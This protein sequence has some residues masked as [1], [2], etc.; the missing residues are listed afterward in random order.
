MRKEDAELF[1]LRNDPKFCDVTFEVKGRKIPVHKNIL[2]VSSVYFKKLFTGKF[3]EST[4]TTIPLE[5]PMQ[6]ESF[7]K[8]LEFIYTKTTNLDTVTTPEL[9][10]LMDF[11]QGGEME[12]FIDCC[13][14]AFWRRLQSDNFWDILSYA[15]KLQNKRLQNMCVLFLNLHPHW[16]QRHVQLKDKSRLE[17]FEVADVSRFLKDKELS[18]VVYKALCDK[19]NNETFVAYC[20]EAMEKNCNALKITCEAYFKI[21]KRAMNK[22][23]RLEF[24]R[25]LTGYTV[26][27]LKS[28]IDDEPLKKKQKGE[29]T[30]SR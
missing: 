16:V 6:A 24:I 28:L 30:L 11:A 27:D 1:D 13:I 8:L 17:L 20:Q 22:E 2:A 14:R 19:L 5:S 4:S 26:D 9:Y 23:Q 18:K 12:D 29:T 25:L 7:E 15:T 3:I 21:N 10:Y